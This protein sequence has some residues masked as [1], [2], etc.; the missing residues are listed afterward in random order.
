MIY[1]YSGTPGSGKS[2]H[3]IKDICFKLKHTGN[4]IANFPIKTE[5]IGKLKGEFIFKE[6]NDLTVDFL[7]NFAY[8]NHTKGKENQTLIVIDEAQALFNPREYTRADRKIYNKFF[9]LHRHLGYNVI[10]ITQND[11]LLDRQIRCLLEYEVKHRNINNYR[12]IGRLCPVKAFAAVTYWY[13]VREKMNVEF[14]LYKK[15]LGNLYDSYALFDVMQKDVPGA[16]EGS[17]GGGSPVHHRTG[18]LVFA[19]NIKKQYLSLMDSIEDFLNKH[20]KE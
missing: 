3:A 9:S 1:L 4:V 15:R 11:R 12:F 19:N 6:D 8:K 5:K 16:D 20:L 2:L 17:G 7:T 14:F 13:G 10:L 18:F